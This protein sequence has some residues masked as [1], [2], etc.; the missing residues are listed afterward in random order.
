M[1]LIAASSLLVIGLLVLPGIAMAGAT[2]EGI[3]KLPP[4]KT[5]SLAGS[6]YKSGAIIGTP[7]PPTAVV[8][9]DVKLA[10]PP[11]ATNVMTQK[12]LQFGPGLLPVQKGTLVQFL[13]LDD[14]FHNVV[15]Y[16]KDKRFD[17]GRYRKDEPQPTVLFDKAGVIDLCCEI[18]EHMRG[19]ILVL[20]TPH[21]VKTDQTGKFRLENLPAGSYTLKAWVNLKTVWS[22]PVELKDGATLTVNFPSP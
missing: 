13:H 21:F 4:A 9:L 11:G 22:A 2:V 5:S 1:K 17:L 3:V 20:E 15:S 18:H 16:S 10:A 14:E 7:E 6:R 19:T 8:Y 12:N